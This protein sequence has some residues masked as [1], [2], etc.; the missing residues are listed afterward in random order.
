MKKIVFDKEVL[1]NFYCCVFQDLDSDKTIVCEISERRNDIKML[2]TIAANY[3]LIGYN[4]EHYDNIIYNYLLKNPDTTNEELYLLSKSIIDKD[5]EY[6]KPWKYGKTFDSIDVMTM[7]ASSALRV[8]LKHLQV[9]TQWHKVQEFE[10]D[11]DAPLPLEDFDKCIEYCINDVESL[12]HVCKLKKKDFDNREKINQITSIDTRSMDG[13][14]IGI[15]ILMQEYSKRTGHTELKDRHVY[16]NRKPHI[17]PNYFNVKYIGNLTMK[18]CIFPNIKF[19]TPEFQKVLKAYQTM[20]FERFYLI[21][22]ADRYVYKLIHPKGLVCFYGLGGT[23]ADRGIAEIITPPKD[24]LFTSVDVNSFYPSIIA[25]Y[26]LNPPHLKPVWNDIYSESRDTRIKAKFS[27]DDFTAELKKLELNATFGQLNSIYSPVY[28][29]KAFYSITI[30][31]QLLLSMLMERFIVAGFTPIS[32][33]TD[34]VEIIY[35]KDKQDLFES[36]KKQ[37]EIDTM[38]TLDQEYY[39]K[40][41]RRDINSY[42]AVKCDENGVNKEYDG[43]LVVKRKGFFE[44]GMNLLK[45]YKYPV[46]KKALYDYF[47][48]G[49]PLEQFIKNH[50]NIYDFC[51]SERM[52]TSKK[53]G[54]PFKA[55]HNGQVLNKTNRFYAAKGLEAG[56]LYKSGDGKTMEHLLKNS[57]VII[58]NDYVEKPMA[59]YRLNYEY[60]IHEAR[61]IVRGIEKEQL[62]LF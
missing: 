23:H 45:G 56:Y 7:L 35:P 60:Y 9:I 12:K 22:E 51:I 42:L 33:N 37:W 29:P 40:M 54:K 52:G 3:T 19:T 14:N 20:T 13:V 55:Y 34:S 32:M 26:K 16:S 10:V 18:E 30:N 27:G 25:M 46:V 44:D 28:A 41:V 17:I 57:G 8:S 62:N 21:K 2:Q 43:E 61:E 39:S 53:T 31:G 1:P 24:H 6:Y 11:W 5:Y 15:S 47:I 4:S 50:D 59:D 38:M 48:K 49:V 58:F 36:I